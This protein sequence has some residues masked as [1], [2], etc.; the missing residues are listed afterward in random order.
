MKWLLLIVLIIVNQSFAQPADRSVAPGSLQI[1]VNGLKN[2]TG[3]IG[4][5]L[6]TQK[7]GFP[8]DYTK[9]FRQ[10]LVSITGKEVTYT[11]TDIPAGNYAVTVMHDENN[12]K[13]LDTNF[14]GIPK[15]GYGF[16]NNVSVS[17]GPPKFDDAVIVV[18]DGKIML[19]INMNY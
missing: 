11:F 1:T 13:K 15:E 7:D 19:E 5:L 8:S 16:S 3:Q 9:A 2:T 10:E 18:Q 14:I 17:F 12:N 4:L 6:F